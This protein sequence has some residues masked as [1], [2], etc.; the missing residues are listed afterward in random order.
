MPNINKELHDLFAEARA[1]RLA[2]EHKSISYDEAQQRV[3]PLL[4][5][6]NMVG[7]SIAKKY[8]VKY[9]KITF[10]NLGRNF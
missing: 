10:E 2:L 6:L 5:K 7:A 3:K 1:I 8:G 9:K 4:S